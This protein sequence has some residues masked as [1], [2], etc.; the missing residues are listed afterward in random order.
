M[1]ST[2]IKP[3]K[4]RGRANNMNR[5][6]RKVYTIHHVASNNPYLI[7]FNKNNANMK[8]SVAC[9]SDYEEADKFCVLLEYQRHFT[10]EWP[11]ID[12][13]DSHM[14]VRMPG[15]VSI[16]YP[17]SLCL[18]E[19]TL[20]SVQEYCAL[21]ILDLLL[22]TPDVENEP[23]QINFKC[24]HYEVESNADTIIQKLTSMYENDIDDE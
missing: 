3:N 2:T 14:F 22:I 24:T 10:K 19:W 12:F 16:M 5:E 6:S 23:Y 11:V 21:N 15:T 8:S 17:R 20:Y 13:E 4:P 9:F 18:Y 7:Q 1:S